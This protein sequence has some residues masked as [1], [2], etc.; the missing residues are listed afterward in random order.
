MTLLSRRSLMLAC[1]TVAAI[2]S[3]SATVQAQSVSTFLGGSGTTDLA[4]TGWTTAGNWNTG[5][6]PTG[7]SVWAQINSATATTLRVNYGSSSVGITGTLTVGAISFQPTLALATGSTYEVRNSSTG[8]RGTLRLYGI[9]TTVDGTSRRIILD[10][11]TTVGD[12][13]VSQS[14][15]GQDFELYTS[16]AINVAAS[17]SLTLSPVIRDGSGTQSITK[18]GQG[19]LSFAG[20]SYA[21]TTTNSSGSSTYAGGFVMSGGIVQWASSGAAGVGTPFGLGAM[22]VRSGTLRSTTSSGRSIYNN[23]ILDGSVT[24]GSTVSGF[25]GNITVNNTS[26]STTIAS[27]SVITTADGVTTDWQQAMSG[28]GGLTKAGSGILNLSGS[29]QRSTFSGGFVADGGIVQWT[30]SGTPGVSTPFGLGSLTLRSGTLRSTGTSSRE[31]NTSVVL[32]GAVTL[33]STVA[34]QTGP[35]T[36]TNSGTTTLASNSILTIVEGGSTAWSQATTG[37]GGFTKAGSGILVFNGA[38][39][40]LNHTGNT[41]VQS[42]TLMMNANLASASAVS[43]LNGATLFGSGTIAGVASTQTGAV[44]SPGAVAGSTGV[45]TFGSSL[46][47][48]GQTLMELTGTTR[49]TQYD[50]FNVAGSLTYGG[51]LQLLFSGTL[52][53]GTY[54]LFSGFGSQAGTFSSISTTGGYAGSLT[55]TAGVWSGTFGSQTL[56]FSNATGDLVIV[57]EPTSLLAAGCGVALALGGFCRRLRRTEQAV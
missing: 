39:G 25:T 14:S 56:T 51:P 23:V 54:N 11:R 45:L 1:F 52:P 55:E 24:L 43:V 42:G 18:I 57:P 16:G 30:N 22:T 12:V 44:L 32:D 46:G 29:T 48:S 38:G 5:T 10:N 26:G 13:G 6:I 15:A 35:I 21:G 40:S 3:H 9:D 37:A 19:V 17:T 53:E 4:Q 34:G 8:T 2:L 28:T 20:V 49:G 47:L 33:G 7:T 31:I 50:A 27:N 41:V 36:V